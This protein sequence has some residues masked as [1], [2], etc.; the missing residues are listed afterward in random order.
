MSCLLGGEDG[1]QRARSPN[2]SGKE[3]CS[4]FGDTPHFA[5]AVAKAIEL[6][7]RGSGVVLVLLTTSAQTSDVDALRPW[8]FMPEDIPAP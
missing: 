7:S 1:L 4:G 5:I 8:G 3:C 2:V 6:D